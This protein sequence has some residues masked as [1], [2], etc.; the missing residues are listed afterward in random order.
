MSTN[1]TI[2]RAI[3]TLS[4]P[5]AAGKVSVR[6]QLEPHDAVEAN[7]V[8]KPL[9]DCTLDELQAYADQLEAALGEA[10]A[11]LTVNA[12]IDDPSINVRVGDEHANLLDC[13][14]L[15]P[16]ND[17][18]E[19]APEPAA[20]ADPEITL[21]EPV[22]PNDPEI[23]LINDVP[24]IED[25]SEEIAA[26]SNTEEPE[27]D[28]NAE[29]IYI[30]EIPPR[31]EAAPSPEAPAEQPRE[32]AI[33]I[34]A[35]EQIHKEPEVNASPTDLTRDPQ[36]EIRTGGI[37]SNG[38]YPAQ[39][40]TVIWLDERPLRIMQAHAKSSMRREV[41]GV[42]VGPR[43]EKQPD[44]R[45]LVHVRDMIVAKHTRMSGASVTYTP[46][47]WRYMNDKLAEKYPDDDMVM[48]GWYH[49]H[50][51]FGIFLSNMDLFIHTNFFTQKWHI[52]YVLD[53]V[54][55]RSGFFSWDRAKANVIPYRFAWPHWAAGSW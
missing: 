23:T 51:G 50:P 2:Y 29:E 4:P 27:E 12:L 33:E 37:M 49:T 44:G 39:N 14:V 17:S 13:V 45:Y 19:T 11:D 3:L 40:A 48:V 30:E 28:A 18:A 34:Q 7:G 55:E 8:L 20:P 16:N 6:L 32:S 5:E 41:A 47:S 25:V 1:Q 46:E 42:M 43:P 26:E 21:V 52:A 31:N 36:P 54:G 35:S 10:Y 53:P 38:N 24:E 9:R 15:L 22:A